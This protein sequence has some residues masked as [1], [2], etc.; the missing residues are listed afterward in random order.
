M[1]TILIL[2]WF[3]CSIFF[4]LFQARRPR[5][6]G[7]EIEQLICLIEANQ[8]AIKGEFSNTLTNHDRREVWH[9][10][11]RKMKGIGLVERTGD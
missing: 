9:I 6:T 11:S 7:A 10:M 3:T 1:E 8:I 5:F 4:F 2:K